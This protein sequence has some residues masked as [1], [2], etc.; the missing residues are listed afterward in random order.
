[1]RKNVLW[2]DEPVGPRWALALEL[3]ASGEYVI[4]MGLGLTFATETPP[5]PRQVG[6]LLRVTV[7]T[8]HPDSLTAEQARVDIENA[9]AGLDE[10]RQRS[11]AFAALVGDREKLFELIDDYGMGAIRLAYKDASGF[12]FTKVK[13]APDE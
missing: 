9:E 13:G 4:C 8:R 6:P 5:H 11:P 3:L 12:H 2:V 7:Q 1:V 10:I